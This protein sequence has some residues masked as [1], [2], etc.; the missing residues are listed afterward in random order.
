MHFFF[1]PQRNAIIFFRRYGHNGCSSEQIFMARVGGKKG[2]FFFMI[3]LQTQPV[4]SHSC[5]FIEGNQ[6]RVRQLL[7]YLLSW[8]H[9]SFQPQDG[10]RD[11]SQSS[12][13]VV[14]T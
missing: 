11:V 7:Y 14:P 5:E 4:K 8:P 12:L 3:I 13:S 9:F 1:C 10:I 6:N 2:Y